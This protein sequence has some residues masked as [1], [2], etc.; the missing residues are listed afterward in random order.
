MDMHL[1]ITDQNNRTIIDIRTK[2][3]RRISYFLQA[4]K[5][6]NSTYYIKVTYSDGFHNDGSYS[7]KKDLLQALQIFTEK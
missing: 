3:K 5:T 2:K 6:Q 1:K 7:H 4:D